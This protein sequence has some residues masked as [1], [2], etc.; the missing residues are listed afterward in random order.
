MF[1]IAVI[2]LIISLLGY[3]RFLSS[4]KGQTIQYSIKIS[5]SLIY[6]ENKNADIDIYYFSFGRNMWSELFSLPFILFSRLSRSQQC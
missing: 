2:Y 1:S 6:S 5:K 4:V 3:K